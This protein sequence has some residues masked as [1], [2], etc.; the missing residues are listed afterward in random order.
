MKLGSRGIKALI[1]LKIVCCGGLLLF[2]YGGFSLG[3]L[4]VWA[5]GNWV[6]W[7]LLVGLPLGFYV[8]RQQRN[9]ADLP[10]AGADQPPVSA[11]SKIPS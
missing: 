3:A 4:V 7:G 11:L 10:A 5:T 1:A 9:R 6:W 8:W 2:I